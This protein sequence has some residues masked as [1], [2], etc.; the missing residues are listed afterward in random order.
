MKYFS[1]AAA[2]AS[3]ILTVI[4]GAGWLALIWGLAATLK[5]IFPAMSVG[6]YP[7]LALGMLLFPMLAYLVQ[8]LFYRPRR[9][10]GPV[11]FIHERLSALPLFF[12]PLPTC[13]SLKT[14]PMLE[15]VTTIGDREFLLAEAR[16]RL[17]TFGL[18]SRLALLL[19]ARSPLDLWLKHLINNTPRTAAIIVKL[20]YLL[21]GPTRQYMLL[22]GWCALAVWRKLADPGPAD[23]LT[24]YKRT[25][26]YDLATRLENVF[27]ESKTTAEDARSLWLALRRV[28]N[29]PEY[30]QKIGESDSPTEEETA[31]AE[32]CYREPWLAS[33]YCGLYLDQPVALP[34]RSLEEL[35]D[36][37]PEEDPALFYPPELGFEAERQ[38]LLTAESRRL[39]SLLADQ[40]GEGIIRL[41]G[42]PVSAWVLEGRIYDID[43]EAA[44]LARRLAGHNRRCRSS[45]MAAASRLGRGWPM[46]IQSL[47]C[48]IHY[49][50]HGRRVLELAEED[51]QAASA[52]GELSEI[53]AA[54]AFNSMLHG[55]RSD[56]AN[57]DL[58]PELDFRN[59]DSDSFMELPEFQPA[60]PEPWL[61]RREA[62]ARE[63]NSNL[64]KLK[65]R[66]L[67]ELLAAED[68]L[69]S[70]WGRKTPREAETAPLSP[71]PAPV[72]T[73]PMPLPVTPERVYS[74]DEELGSGVV[75]TVLAALLLALLLWKGQTVGQS[76][77]A[78]YN[79]LGRPITVA[80]G[81]RELTLGPYTSGTM[82]L[83][84]NRSHRI[85]ARDG[86]LVVESFELQ[87][88]SVPA[89]EVYNV[90]GAAPLMQWFI[91]HR[92][93][94]D[95]ARFLGR[96]RCLVTSAEI[97]F[98]VP[99][100]KTDGRVSVLSAYGEIP[101]EEMLAAFDDEEDRAEL[102]R[103]HARWDQPG[104]P[105][106]W[107]WQ[108]LMAGQPD[109]AALLLERLRNEPDFLD[110]SLAWLYLAGN[111][112]GSLLP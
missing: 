67:T 11:V 4:F 110:R 95:A 72:L 25:L 17:V 12:L 111:D 63:L 48:L 7:A 36:N 33:R 58:T 74:T 20:L 13:K 22:W 89:A 37:G 65:G 24:A 71:C 66:A 5:N 30:S 73:T 56:L 94:T 96:P 105:W 82:S 28:R 78:V 23:E 79:G 8:A 86:E 112:S 38:A 54:A 84:P 46:R 10:H 88:Q 97:I 101:P 57:L 6:N 27:G 2:A 1:P 39:K 15:V 16:A 64:L 14:G 40:G 18:A 91:P 75:R 44:A 98:K 35:Y 42:R 62:A 47:L 59:P 76:R 103:L 49:A 69:D 32:A 21:M 45:H 109:Q 99:P 60:D 52:A 26:A 55:L 61:T 107:T 29:N 83:W 102:I 87:F 77:L 70:L 19:E 108:A 51:F 53:S 100:S 9:P 68:F 92:G 50:E 85:T 81:G 41:D 31:A 3:L 90:A 34:A 43:E 106:F 80:A 104:T 93:D